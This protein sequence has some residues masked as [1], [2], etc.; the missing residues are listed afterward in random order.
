MRKA[1]QIGGRI[2]SILDAFNFIGMR[3]SPL[4]W[5]QS[6]SKAIRLG[7]RAKTDPESRLRGLKALQYMQNLI[8]LG[9]IKLTY[10]DDQRRRVCYSEHTSYWLTAIYPDP[11]GS[12][13]GMI[14]LDHSDI[15]FGMVDISGIIDWSNPN[16]KTPGR[17]PRFQ[18]FDEALDLF[19]TNNSIETK[20][21]SIINEIR[22]I[23]KNIDWPGRSVMYVRIDEARARARERFRYLN[24]GISS[25]RTQVA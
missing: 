25:G 17:T 18:E 1:P 14:Q 3:L 7:Q 5:D 6:E 16:K 4:D 12:G 20:K 23:S 21:S 15:Y 22:L 9:D 24:S 8:E 2:V 13:E 19:F 10:T 11:V